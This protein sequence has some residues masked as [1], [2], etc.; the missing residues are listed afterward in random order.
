ET[1]I[2][3]RFPDPAKAVA[4]P[5]VAIEGGSVGYAAGKPVLKNMSLR[6]DNDDRIALLGANGNGK[7]T[8]AKLL[9]GRLGLE[10]GTMTLAPGLKVAIF[11]QHQL[12]DLRPEENAIEH[13]RRLMP[14]APEA[15]VR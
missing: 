3:F 11:A 12:D 5:I 7:S 13:V 14:D 15:R 6:I 10:A 2:P 8:F 1:V 9:A 4:S